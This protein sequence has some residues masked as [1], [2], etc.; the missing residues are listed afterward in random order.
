MAATG[1]GQPLARENVVP[2]ESAMLASAPE[3]L[4]YVPR[5]IDLPAAVAQAIVAPRQVGPRT[6][7]KL[8]SRTV[9]VA[10]AV[11]WA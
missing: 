2:H 9:D 11:V 6:F 7:P 5:C 10:G 4:A 3:P 8:F 1:L